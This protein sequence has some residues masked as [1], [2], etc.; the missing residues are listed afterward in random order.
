MRFR[1]ATPPDGGRD[2]GCADGGTTNGG[3][4]ACGRIPAQAQRWM[5]T[6]S[7]TSRVCRAGRRYLV[8][9]AMGSDP[10]LVADDHPVV[11]DGSRP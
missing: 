1:R 9:M 11:A 2:S 7:L 3:H 8:A 6:D 5:C 4:S 10:D